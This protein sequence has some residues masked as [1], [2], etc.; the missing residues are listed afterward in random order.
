MAAIRRTLLSWRAVAAVSLCLNVFLI[1]YL[2]SQLFVRPRPPA[3][4]FAPPM[5]ISRVADMLPA[6]DARIL[7][8]AFGHSEAKITAAHN[9]YRQFLITASSLLRQP[10]IDET[11][12]KQAVEEA[13]DKRQVVGDLMINVF[14]EALPKMSLAGREMILEKSIH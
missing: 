1:A 8:D 11:A 12:L 5:L 13:R 10:K 6:G 3:G 9:D 14:L 2:G 7:W 4:G